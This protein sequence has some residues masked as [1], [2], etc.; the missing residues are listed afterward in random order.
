M[1]SLLA[2]VCPMIRLPF[3]GPHR[4]QRCAALR[5]RNAATLL[6]LLLLLLRLFTLA[7]VSRARRYGRLGRT[8]EQ[9]RLEHKKTKVGKQRS[10]KGSAPLGLSESLEGR[11]ERRE[12]GRSK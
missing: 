11:E 8:R 12:R 9:L 4:A 1:F 5:A 10:E 2:Q 7:S 3:L 6:L